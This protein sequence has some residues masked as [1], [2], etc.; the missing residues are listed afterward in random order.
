MVATFRQVGVFQPK[1][2]EV[3]QS[4]VGVTD[5]NPIVENFLKDL[6]TIVRK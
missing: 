6:K 3:T 1:E 4:A 5:K 2:K